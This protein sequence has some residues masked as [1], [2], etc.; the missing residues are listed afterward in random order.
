MTTLPCTICTKQVHNV[1]GEHL[2]DDILQPDGGLH[3]SIHTGYG[4]F[5]DPM[6]QEASHSL[7]YIMLCHDCSIKVIDLFPQEFKEKF[8]IGGH[9]VETCKE[10]SNTHPDGCHYAWSML[11]A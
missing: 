3:L 2:G 10:Q 7:W 1:F 5:T 9:A 4:M 8:F 6:T 11:N